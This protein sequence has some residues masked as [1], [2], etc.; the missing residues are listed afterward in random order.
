[1]FYY[2]ILN[3]LAVTFKFTLVISVASHSDYSVSCYSAILLLPP[4]ECNVLACIV[5][6]Y[7]LCSGNVIVYGS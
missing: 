6:P 7:R 3:L 4:G 5:I 2:D 1:M